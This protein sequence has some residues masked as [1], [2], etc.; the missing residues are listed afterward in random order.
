MRYARTM[1]GCF[2]LHVAPSCKFFVICFVNI[3]GCI[4]LVCLITSV[5][6]DE[7]IKGVGVV[8]GYCA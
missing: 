2:V 6:F 4:E 8:G 5:V 7:K 3:N 1:R